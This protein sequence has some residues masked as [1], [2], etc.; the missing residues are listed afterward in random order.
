MNGTDAALPSWPRRPR[1]LAAAVVEDLV[2]RIV[3]GDMAAG[4]TLPIEPVLCEVFAVSRTVIREAV[5]S[6]E[7]MRLVK[8][9]QGH[10]TTVCGADGWDLLNPV[11][12]AASIRHDAELDIL[13][14]LIDVRQA[15]EGQMAAEAAEHADAK[16]LDRIESAFTHLFAEEEDPARFLRADLDFHDA[17]MAASGNR[18]ARAVIH[19]VNTE[20]F[21]S[22]R[23]LGETTQQ[24][25]VDSNV[26]HRRIYERITDRDGP[27]AADA[28]RAHILRSWRHRRPSRPDDR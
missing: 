25:C 20:A 14:D 19:T 27:G 13:D 22:L 3:G 28:I 24:D 18:L 15:L 21:H 6:L 4:T 11:V 17:I 26:E 12:L 7:G 8:V 2:D 23:Y 10:G 5:K 1:R 16:Q 9:Q